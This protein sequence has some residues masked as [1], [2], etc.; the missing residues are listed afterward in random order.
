M[1]KITGLKKVLRHPDV[2]KEAVER[3]FKVIVRG[4]KKR[5]KMIYIAFG[6]FTLIHYVVTLLL[7]LGGVYL[8]IPAI[9]LIG[10]ILLILF[11]YSFKGGRVFPDI[12]FDASHF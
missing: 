4:I 1:E 2:K 10:F 5:Q 9:M 11:F 6:I 8:S 3:D 7:D 12:E